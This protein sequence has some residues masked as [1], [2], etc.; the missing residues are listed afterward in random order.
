VTQ[1]TDHLNTALAGRYRIERQLGEGGMATV[2]LCED[3]KHKRKVALKLLKPELAAVLG[4]ERFVQEITT[5][6]A[7]Q[8]PHILPLFDSGTADGFLF[9]VMP[10]IEGETLREK[11]NRETQLSVDEAVRI[12]REV[13]DALDYAHQHGIVH[14]DVKPENILLHG[15]HAMVADFGIALA[16][17]A[18]AG[19]R[20]TETGLSLGTP[21]YMSPEQA[22]AEKEITAR[23]DIYS[24][25]SVLY[26]MLTGNPPFVGAVAQQIIMKIITTPAEPVTLHRK[27]VPTNVAAAVAK[28]LEKLP[29]DR[30]ESA[31]KFAE[32]LGNPSYT[33][34]T[35]TG[36]TPTL[37]LARRQRVREAVFV[38][39]LVA[40]VVAPLTWWITARRAEPPL[41]V[42]FA[43][44]TAPSQPLGVTTGRTV[45]LSPDGRTVVY[46][47]VD[48]AGRSRLFK[49][50]LDDLR[51]QPIDG[52]E[53]GQ[54]PFFSPDGRSLG[55]YD[56][57]QLRKIPV[58]GGTPTSLADVQ[59]LAG[60][61][62]GPDGIV[63]SIS[64]KLALVPSMGGTPVP[65]VPGDSAAGLWPVLSPD[66]KVAVYATTNSGT[67]QLAVAVLST[68]RRVNLGIPGRAPLGF[69]GGELIFQRNDGALVAIPLDAGAGR[70]TGSP[71]VVVAEVAQSPVGAAKAAL[72]ASGSLAYL[73]GGAIVQAVVVDM[74]GAVRPLAV[75]AGR[76]S[77]PRYSP[78][79]RRLAADLS[80]GGHQDVWIY[81]V[82]SGAAHRMTSDGTVNSR[83][84][85]TPDGTRI[86]FRTDRKGQNT[87]LWSQPA[88]G[89][90]AAQELVAAPGKD[91]W[92]GMLTPDS[93]TVVYRTGSTGLADIWYRRLSADTAEHGIA[94]TPFN[95]F[96]PRVSPDGRWVA[97]Q[98]NESG[99][100]EVVVRPFPG[101]GAQFPVSVGGGT[102]P[103]WSRDGRR[104][105]YANGNKLL[106][107]TVGTSPT[108]SVT[109]RDVLF[110][111]NY[112]LAGA[113]G[114]ANFDVAPDGKSLLML[115]PIIAGGEQIVVI[116][117]WAAELRASAKAAT[118]R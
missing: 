91:V 23:S 60:A 117:N 44:S 97:Y 63:A 43:F 118:P 111:G 69:V 21:H 11:L 20:M 34:A 1:Q 74:K 112:N 85:W 87:T 109:A 50:A 64:G 5:T 10:L 56:G 83:P 2:Y 8:H 29:A 82:A 90:G 72:S 6:A 42:H 30:F 31:A 22:T 41:A 27:A 84:E 25:G 94:T 110:E 77:S 98:S 102:T 78:D 92:E 12:A 16:V 114:H 76:L 116:P 100:N 53:D 18:A 59:G 67:A 86:L 80:S 79:G 81:D 101:P 9:Y 49:R 68:G 13:A 62:W 46:S 88:D 66:G 103:I 71:H 51:Q 19:G 38:G 26:E 61:S 99:S 70:V 105:F 45:A 15:G 113:G 48:S 37:A 24:I 3:I 35:S 17:S 96:G 28:S 93:R 36:V 54:Q 47:T 4:A 107:A 58:D 89:S 106:A 40:A 39:V 32:A 108:F 104:I 115:R 75:P 95:E 57:R 7:L 14:R 33:S 65:L 52:S 55:F 73:G